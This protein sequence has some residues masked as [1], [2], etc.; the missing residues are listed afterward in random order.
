[1][2]ASKKVQPKYMNTT[3]AIVAKV[4]NAFTTIT[5]YDIMLPE[6]RRDL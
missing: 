2:K 6:S 4:K 5:G 3:A 1:M